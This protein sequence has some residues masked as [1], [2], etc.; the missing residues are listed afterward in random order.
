MGTNA[1][2]N[3]RRARLQLE[4]IDDELSCAEE[5]RHALEAAW[6]AQGMDPLADPET[7]RR[8]LRQVDELIRLVRRRRATVETLLEG[9]GT[10][11]RD[12]DRLLDDAASQVRSRS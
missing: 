9:L 10:T 11:L 8:G 7:L 12:V 6:R 5:L 4:R 1:Y 3:L 2:I